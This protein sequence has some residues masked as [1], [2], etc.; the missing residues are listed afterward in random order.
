MRG[1][2]CYKKKTTARQ[3]RKHHKIFKNNL[4]AKR[5]KERDFYCLRRC[6]FVCFCHCMALSHFPLTVVCLKF[7]AIKGE[8]VFVENSLINANKLKYLST[9]G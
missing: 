2:H 6:F 5:R 1:F 9:S 7:N 3:R 8:Y 4:Q